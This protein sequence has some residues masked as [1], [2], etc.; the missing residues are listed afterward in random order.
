MLY[1]IGSVAY[2]IHLLIECSS[3]VAVAT[4]VQTLKTKTTHWIKS[5][6]RRLAGFCWQ[7]GYGVFSVRRPALETVLN[8][9]NNQ[10]EHH[11]VNTFEEEWNWLKGMN[12]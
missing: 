12:G 4:L 7:E 2:Y 6:D 5:Q 8:Y 11:R 9:V 10:K 1:S 3:K